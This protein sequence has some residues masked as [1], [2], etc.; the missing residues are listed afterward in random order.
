[1]TTKQWLRRARGIDREI[2]ALI[3]AKEQELARLLSITAK[4]RHWYFSVK[5]QRL[6]LHMTFLHLRHSQTAFP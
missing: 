3:E 2:D 1:M 5:R 4:T 6:L